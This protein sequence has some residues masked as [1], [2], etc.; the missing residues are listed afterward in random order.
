MKKV[1][2]TLAVIVDRKS[3]K[4]VDSF[5]FDFEDHFAYDFIDPNTSIAHMYAKG[6]A[7]RVFEEKQKYQPRLRKIGDWFVDCVFL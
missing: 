4:E 1:L 6:Q 5:E 2:R 7:M 3:G